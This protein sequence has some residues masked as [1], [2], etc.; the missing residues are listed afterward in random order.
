MKTKFMSFTRFIALFLSTIFLFTTFSVLNLIESNQLT[1][2]ATDEYLA[3]QI[4]AK[5]LEEEFYDVDVSVSDSLMNFEGRK[6]LIDMNLSSTEEN[7]ILEECGYGFFEP[8]Y[9]IDLD[10]ETGGANTQIVMELN[11]G[12]VTAT[13]HNLYLTDGNGYEILYI[14]D[15]EETFLFEDLQQEA[16]NEANTPNSRATRGL[17]SWI[18]KT[19]KSIGNVIENLCTQTPAQTAVAVFTPSLTVLSTAIEVVSAPIITNNN[20]VV[21]SLITNIYLSNPLNILGDQEY[22]NYQH[23]VSEWHFGVNTLDN[24]GCGVIATFNVLSFFGQISSTPYD[25]LC[26]IISYYENTNSCVLSGLLGLNPNAIS[27]YLVLKGLR[28]NTHTRLWGQGC[29]QTD[30]DDLQ[31]DQIGILLYWFLDES[32]PKAHYVCIAK[33]TNGD[34]RVINSSN[35]NY[36]NSLNEFFEEK[37]NESITEVGFMQGWTVS[38]W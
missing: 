37:K 30:M 34:K 6:E 5:L 8:L 15:E 11:D 9:K 23:L 10:L 29:F 33:D 17:F 13:S 35:T 4:E 32:I 27:P 1:A 28:V 31:D 24:N 19:L 18:R 14:L 38:L 36:F 7:A 3:N 22:I 20:S 26:N 2:N 12:T 16:I 25:D 21:N